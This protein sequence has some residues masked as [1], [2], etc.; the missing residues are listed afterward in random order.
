MAGGA[1]GSKDLTHLILHGI[2]FTGEE[3]G[4]GAFGRVLE[5]DYGGMRC[6]AKE[7]HELLLQ[8]SQG[9]ALQK[10]K[11]DFITECFVWSTLRHPNVVLFLGIYYPLGEESGLP[12][13]VM[14]KMQ[15][16]IRS[17]VEKYENIPLLVKLSILH[18]ICFGLRYLHGLTP[19]IIHR[20]LSTNNILVTPRLVAKITDLGQ[21][22]LLK[23]ESFS[24][25]SMAPGTVIFMPP[26][27]LEFR[28]LYGP[29]LDIFSFGA[30]TLHLVTQVWPSPS[31]LV[32]FDEETGRREMVPE[33]TRRKMYI[34][35][36]TGPAADLVPLVVSCLEDNPNKRPQLKEV[37]D[38]IA[39]LMS[40]L[41]NNT[42]RD[43]MDVPAWLC[44]ISG[45]QDML[46]DIQL[47]VLCVYMCMCLLYSVKC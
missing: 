40:T 8:Y 26:E 20:D 47:S 42:T 27:A 11:D 34:D 24:T 3:L 1:R 41:E 37:T 46:P 9:E 5:V 7:I 16:S 28:P 14:E 43:G 2:K 31:A 45:G 4:R 12:V 19:A 10:L 22:K 17:L 15:E 25:M 6:A 39:T 13:M 23:V 21:A 44:D 18:D 33:V 30:V 32:Q 36:M 38:T 35:L 29:Q